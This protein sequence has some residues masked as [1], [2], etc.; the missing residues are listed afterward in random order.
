[1]KVTAP[2]FSIAPALNSGTNSWS[3]FSNG[4]AYPNFSSKYANPRRVMS[5]M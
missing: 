4:Y 5:K 2:A 1:V 3:Y